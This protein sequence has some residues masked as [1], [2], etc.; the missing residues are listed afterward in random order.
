[1]VNYDIINL[2]LAG[3][4]GICSFIIGRKS[5][6]KYILPKDDPLSS[7]SPGGSAL[8]LKVPLPSKPK[9]EVYDID[10]G[11]YNDN[12]RIKVLPGELSDEKNISLLIIDE[13]IER[14]LAM[15]IF[16]CF[17]ALLLAVLI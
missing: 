17:V 4:I 16:I 7:F 6:R 10:K 1:M 14:R 15:S 11:F 9:I 5:V 8:P 12:M 3:I 2:V 13:G